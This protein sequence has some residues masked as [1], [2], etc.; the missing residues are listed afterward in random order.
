[1]GTRRLIASAVFAS[2]FL[3]AAATAQQSQSS[4]ERELFDA[5][6]R[7]RRAQGLPSLKWDDALA[8]AARK[9]AEQMAQQG[10]IAHQFPGEPSLPGRANQ[11]GARFVWLAENVDQSTS[12]GSIHER[13]MKSPLHRANILDRDMDSVGIGIVVRGGQW[14]AVEDFSKAK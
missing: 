14:F 12:A 1:M 7:E 4:G 13:L 2:L 10:S 9:H 5:A 6:N 3:F 11:A 8:N